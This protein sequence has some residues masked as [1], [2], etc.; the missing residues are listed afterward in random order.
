MSRLFADKRLDSPSLKD[1][2]IG[3]ITFSEEVSQSAKDVVGTNGQSLQSRIREDS[4]VSALLLC[5]APRILSSPKGP[6]L[7][8]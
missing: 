8:T 2:I 7:S 6:I 4:W 3:S 5:G 1:N